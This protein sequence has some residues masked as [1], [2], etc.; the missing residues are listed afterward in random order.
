MFLFLWHLVLC[1]MYDEQPRIITCDVL[2]PWFCVHTAVQHHTFLA[3]STPT[4]QG[5]YN[6]CGLVPHPLWRPIPKRSKKTVAVGSKS[7]QLAVSRYIIYG[8]EVIVVTV[9]CSVSYTYCWRSLTCRLLHY[10]VPREIQ[11]MKNANLCFRENGVDWGNLSRFRKK[12]T[13]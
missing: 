6:L 9:H 3:I 1:Q 12:R 4:G 7:E 8:S 10:S 2:T 13:S 5:L 11:K